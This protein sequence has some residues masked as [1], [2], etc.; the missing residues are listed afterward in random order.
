LA[1]RTDLFNYLTGYSQKEDFRALRAGH[2]AQ[3]LTE[4]IQRE[5]GPGE[6]GRLIFK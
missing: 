2:Y 4:L 3:K 1:R 6:R 5:I